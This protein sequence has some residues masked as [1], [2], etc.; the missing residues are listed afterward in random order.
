M[1]RTHLS[2]DSWNPF[3]LELLLCRFILSKEK[4]D[5]K[6]PNYC[7]SKD[8][9]EYVN[10]KQKY[11]YL[12][13]DQINDDVNHLIGLCLLSIVLASKAKLFGKEPV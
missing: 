10:K 6:Q 12:L 3:L 9:A 11:K 13:I 1:K 2:Q 8:D 7:G 4:P 5:L